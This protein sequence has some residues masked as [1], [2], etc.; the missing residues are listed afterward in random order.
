MRLGERGV[1]F[2]HAQSIGESR[3]PFGENG[4]LGGKRIL[5]FG[6]SYIASITTA[7]SPCGMAHHQVGIRL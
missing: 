2:C 5:I 1:L 4:V 3:H 7:Q 6:R